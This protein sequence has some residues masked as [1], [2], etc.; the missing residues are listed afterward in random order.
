MRSTFTAAVANRAA[1]RL[2][3]WASDPRLLR[4]KSEAR[5]SSLIIATEVYLYIYLY[6]GSSEEQNRQQDP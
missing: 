1:I 2:A 5:R 4:S 3:R 6:P